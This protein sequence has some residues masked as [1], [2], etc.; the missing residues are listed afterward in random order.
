MSITVG[1]AGPPHRNGTVAEFRSYG[2][3]TVS[4]VAEMFVDNDR[5]M[6]GFY[7]REGGVAWDFELSSFLEAIGQGMAILRR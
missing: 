4:I 1:P 6:I 2:E 7:S 5:M 3:S